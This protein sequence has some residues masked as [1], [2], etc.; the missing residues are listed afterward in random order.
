[1]SS[2]VGK[3]APEFVANAIINGNE[4]INNFSLKQYLEKKYVVLLFYTKDF[5]G[6]CPH[7]LLDF[8]KKIHEFESRS[9]QL[10]ACS[11]DTEETH[12]AWLRTNKEDG[13]VKGVNFPIISDH[14]KLITSSFDVLFGEYFTNDDQLL[15]ADGPMIPLRGLFL[16]DKK[17]VVQHQIVNFFTLIR[18]VDHILSTIDSL[19]YFETNGE[20]CRVND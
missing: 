15:D 3:K 1:M 10:V 13:G 20:F 2:I 17:G 9:T 19:H 16:I 12:M 6:I 4:L 11:T 7:E 5:S 18:N 14:S 8:Q